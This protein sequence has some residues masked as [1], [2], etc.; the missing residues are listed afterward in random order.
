[1]PLPPDQSY[2]IQGKGF[3]WNK[4]IEYCANI[5]KMQKWM[6]KH[7]YNR[8]QFIKL[9]GIGFDRGRFIYA[10]G[11]FTLHEAK[12]LAVLVGMNLYDFIDIFLSDIYP[13]TQEDFDIVSENDK[14]K[15]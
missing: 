11:N 9:S 15:K 14:N 12:K 4:E 8:K 2:R 6:R 3:D 10:R 7:G 1:M 5:R 13:V